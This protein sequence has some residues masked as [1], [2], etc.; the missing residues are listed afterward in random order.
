MTW[1]TTSARSERALETRELALDKTM[2]IA[3][4]GRNVVVEV[5]R[6]VVLV[7][8]EG[9]PEDHVLERGMALRLPGEGLV[10]A[11]AL[12][13]STVSVR[14]ASPRVAGTTPAHGRIALTR[15]A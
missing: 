6:G 15:S 2:R 12:A 3:R 9:D 10:V 13:P 11:W 5:E 4:R 14:E 8:R 7:T 1:R